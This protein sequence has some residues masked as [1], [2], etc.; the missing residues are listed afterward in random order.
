M[1]EADPIRVDAR[2]ASSFV[3]QEP[4]GVVSDEQAIQLLDH[5]DGFQAAQR[6]TCQPL[7]GVHFVN[8]P[9]DFPPFVIAAGQVEG[10]IDFW[11]QECGN[12]AM[13][14][15][16][17]RQGSIQNSVLDDPNQ[18]ALAT[19][20]ALIG[21]GIKTSQPGPVRQGSY[22][23]GLGI[24][25]QAARTSAP[26][27]CAFTNISKSW[28]PRSHMINM[29]FSNERNMRN[30]PTRSLLWQGQKPAS[31]IAWVPHSAKYTA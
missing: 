23:L 12:Q 5:T 1:H 21:G 30:P 19:L 3:H 14:L 16:V 28:N 18:E 20:A 31:T 24:G 15:T 13:A 7:V 27:F 29:P 6:A 10:R 11:I 17:S 8:H 2:L 25:G 26:C 22:Q 9:F 4:D